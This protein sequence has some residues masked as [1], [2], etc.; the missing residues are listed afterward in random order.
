MNKQPKSILIVGGGTAG[1]MTANSLLHAWPNCQITLIE[2]DTAALQEENHSLLHNI[3][4]IRNRLKESN[5]TL[6]QKRSELQT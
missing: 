3:D 1:W 5:N 6:A 4:E 2:S